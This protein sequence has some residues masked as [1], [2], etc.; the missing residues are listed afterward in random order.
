VGSWTCIHSNPG[1]ANYFSKGDPQLAKEDFERF[2][3][4]ANKIGQ[5][6][7]SIEFA[8]KYISEIERTAK[9]A[10]HMGA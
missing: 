6:N 1:R 7:R 2:V 9:E 3:D 8:Q 5:F 4:E 10:V